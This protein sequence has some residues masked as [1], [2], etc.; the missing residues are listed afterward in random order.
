MAILIRLILYISYIAPSFLPLNSLPNSL[1]AI[2]TGSFVLVYISVWIHSHVYTHL[3]LLHSPLPLPLVT[4]FTAPILQSCFSFLTFKLIFKRV[5]QC[6]PAVVFVTLVGSSISITF[7]YP[8]ILHSPFFNSF[9]THPYFLNLHRS[10]VLW[11][12]WCSITIPISLSPCP[13]E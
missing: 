8:L 3:H 9:N 10:Y 7:P 12:F 13:I 11:Y 1:K 5:S 2:T 6:I 4:P